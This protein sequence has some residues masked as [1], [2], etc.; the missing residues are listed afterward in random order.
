MARLAWTGALTCYKRCC[1]RHF[2]QVTTQPRAAMSCEAYGCSVQTIVAEQ[3]W[4][5]LARGLS[6]S[7]AFVRL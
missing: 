3:V 2:E 1:E 6:T 7:L 5:R 4:K